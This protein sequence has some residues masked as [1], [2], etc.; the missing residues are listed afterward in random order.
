M[1][2][3]FL[4][5]CLTINFTVVTIFSF[6]KLS[7]KLFQINIDKTSAK[8]TNSSSKRRYLTPAVT[9]A[10]RRTAISA[11]FKREHFGVIGT[12]KLNVRKHMLY[13]RSSTE[14]HV[15]QWS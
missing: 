7:K 10:K 13:R 11:D 9:T 14:T 4:Y 12:S 5:Q 3:I 6:E 15:F 2:F 1:N 8:R